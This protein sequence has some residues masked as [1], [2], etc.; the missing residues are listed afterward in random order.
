MKPLPWSYSSYSTFENCPRQYHGRYVTK[1]VKDQGN[2]QSIYG[3]RVHKDF[4]NFTN[5]VAP[6]PDDVIE[7]RG[8]LQS[9]MDKPGT[10][11]A[12]QKV[13]LNAKRQ[14]THFFATDVWWRGVIDFKSVHEPERRALIVDYK[15][16]KPHNKFD[17]LKLCALHT[18]ALHPT[19]DI[20]QCK[21]YWTQTRSVSQAVYERSQIPD[22]WAGF[23]PTLRQYVDA[24]KTDTWQ[25]RQSGLC[26]EHCAD[27]SCEFNGRR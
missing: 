1:E 21:Y 10:Y 27:L 8:F 25:P 3:T 16:G 4:E 19:I 22:L 26:K 20:V 24:F 15:T 13:G 11:F 12:E 14:P 5:G 23:V 17:Q 2:E 9:L 7:H 18:F 6:L